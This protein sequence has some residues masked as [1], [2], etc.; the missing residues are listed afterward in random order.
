MSDMTN[1]EVDHL[2]LIPKR[3]G[4]RLR[5][6][7]RHDGRPNARALSATIIAPEFPDLERNLKLY[8]QKFQARSGRESWTVAIQTSGIKQPLFRIDKHDS[9]H[10]NSDGS[11][12]RGWMMHKWTVETK[13]R[14]GE[15]AEQIVDCSHVDAALMGFLNYCNITLNE[16]YQ[17][18]W[19]GDNYGRV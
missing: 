9:P 7:R 14:I 15:S 6:E 12:I 1:E 3:I 4:E 19:D 8:A 10:S 17:M 16:D 2:L 18:R 11:I 5:W 13:D